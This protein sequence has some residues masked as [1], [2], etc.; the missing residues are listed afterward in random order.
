MRYPHD[1]PIFEKK[2]EILKVIGAHPVVIICGETGSGK[3][4][5]I[6]K[7]CLEAGRG[8]T[9]WIGCT[10]PRRIA[11]ITIAHRIAEEIGER[12]GQTVGYKIRFHEKL[13][14]TS[15]IK[16]MTD[17]ILLAE[18]QQDPLLRRYD[19]V[20]VD[21]AHERSIN[22]DFIL[23][24]LRN[25]LHQRKDLKVIITSATLDTEKFSRAF[26]HAPVIEISGRMYDVAMQYRPLDQELEEKGERTY[27]D[28]AADTAAELA[29]C[30]PDGDILVFMPTE[31]DIRECC[32]ILRGRL[33]EGT[34]VVPMFARLSWREQRRAFHPSPPRKVIVATNIAETSLTI[35]GIRFVVDTGLAR[36]LRYNP[37]SGTTSLPIVPISQSSAD[38]RKGRCGRV[39]NGVCVRL[40]SEND[41]RERPKFNTPE[42]LRSN[43][44][45]VILKMLS[46]NMKDIH[47]FPFIDRPSGKAVRD[48]FTLLTELGA[49]MKNNAPAPASHFYRLT[50]K[51]R[52]MAL[53]PIDPRVSR[54]I[55]EA[56][57]GHFLR[58]VV[59][60]AS[61]LSIQDPRERPLEKQNEAD[62]LHRVMQHPQSDFLTLLNIWEQYGRRLEILK[63]QNKIRRYCRENF[64]SYR[65]MREWQ[66]VYHEIL[67]ILAQ[68]KKFRGAVPVAARAEAVL[69]EAQIYGSPFYTS[70]HQS[71]LSGYLSQIARKKEKNTF[72]AAKGKT[73][74][75]FP[76]SGLF[77]SSG[78]WIVAAE[79]LETSRLYARNVAQIEAEWLEKLG[80]HL[81]RK[82]YFDPHW[83]KE[84]GDVVA[85]MQVSLFG[86]II[87]PQKK[88]AYGAIDPEGASEIFLDALVDGEIT[89][90]MSFLDH[91]RQV[92][93][94]LRTYEK[95]LRKRDL[96]VNREKQIEFYRQRL[97]G[98]YSV[99]GLK[100]M[101]FAQGSDDFLKMTEEDLLIRPVS[102]AAMQR[103]FP[104]RLQCDQVTLD[105]LY[106]F[107][108]GS[109]RDGAT[110]RVPVSALACLK[111]RSLDWAVLGFREARLFSLIKTL[112]KPYRKLLHPL[113]ETASRIAASDFPAEAFSL[114]A[115]SRQIKDSLGIEIPV[116]AWQEEKLD[117]HLRLR[118]EII[119]NDD[120]ILFSG[121]DLKTLAGKCLRESEDEAL[122][123][124]RQSWERDRL[125]HFDID[126][127][128]EAVP[129]EAGGLIRGYFYPAFTDEGNTFALRLFKDHETAAGE[130]RKGMIVC[131]ALQIKEKI[132]VFRKTM[133]TDRSLI[134]TLNR[135][136]E[137][138]G[139]IQGI[140]CKVI[141]DL[142]NV[143]ARNRDAFAESLA[144]GSPR[145]ISHG[146]EWLQIL[147]PVFRQYE[148]VRGALD[149]LMQAN[150]SN[151]ALNAYLN[152]IM[153]ALHE[154]LPVDF[155]LDLKKEE[156]A[157]LIRYMKALRIRAERGSLDLEKDRRKEADI[158]E[159]I[160]IRDA[161][162]AETGSTGSEGKKTMLD[163]LQWLIREY[164]VSVFAQELKT[165]IPVSRKRLLAKISE[166]RNVC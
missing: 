142:F 133:L 2:K 8:K 134:A 120:N 95:K 56:R 104:D 47:G 112:P 78:R 77:R 34:P 73:V 42:I 129:I 93:E 16:I 103:D 131:Y 161:F 156:T 164:Q 26:N 64:L 81:C 24:I 71:V 157:H 32:D 130:H 114:P 166:I 22:I 11:A 123:N 113:K 154:L 143:C 49:V 151:A 25:I 136:G 48:A 31:Q 138:Q 117:D 12:I 91:N 54:M 41:Y 52:I 74:Y 67:A 127:L 100:K 105:L 61:A 59:V 115:L 66:D 86:L 27:I 90:K 159:F 155:L 97:P 80:E 33:E 121:R 165:A 62:A 4:T 87:V 3:S 144:L 158:L 126:V 106:E 68:D 1:L 99:G 19:T 17:G 125:T 111:G 10:Q 110:L 70:L 44:A 39:R 88:M 82:H 21:E 37:R 119:G 162:K 43:L 135:L 147:R 79:F 36:I 139:R 46:L 6:P 148:E 58:E 65:R 124:A 9:G 50:D 7:I 107:D 30:E 40:Y 69:P 35:P 160:K 149:Q 38:Q 152:H 96:L 23:G 63:S 94:N 92:W 145:F 128:P 141:A 53:L 45:G 153:E 55:I 13:T 18:T 137:A 83:D 132:A 60:I 5:Q 51:G 163:E 146:L 15:V 116:S 118:Y 140:I 14:R 108:P 101:I 20:I 84:K 102:G 109:E 122:E 76:G 98:I 57:H 75:I 89:R 28:A 72:A 150:R 29:K 85:Y